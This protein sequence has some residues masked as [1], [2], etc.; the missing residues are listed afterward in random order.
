[1]CAIVELDKVPARRD[2]R[3]RNLWNLGYDYQLLLPPAG[4]R[5]VDVEAGTASSDA[6]TACA[7]QDAIIKST[8]AFVTT[9]VSMRV[10]MPDGQVRRWL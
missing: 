10:P 1:M 7:A 9:P 8:D 5:V 3:L 2:P 6:T 4:G